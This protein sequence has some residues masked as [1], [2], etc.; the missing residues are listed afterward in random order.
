LSATIAASG[1]D[2]SY[3]FAANTLTAVEKTL[4]LKKKQTLP[5]VPG[6][7]SPLFI[8]L[9]SNTW[10]GPVTDVTFTPVSV[11]TSTMVVIV[12]RGS[13]N[14]QLLTSHAPA[15]GYD[16]SLLNV[17]ANQLT[18]VV[19]SVATPLTFTSSTG[20]GSST[21][22]AHTET[23]THT[24]SGETLASVLELRMRVA[25][26]VKYTSKVG[27]GSTSPVSISVSVVLPLGPPTPYRVAGAPSVA[28]SNSIYM[29]NNGN[30]EV[31]VS[32]NA[33]GLAVEG[34]STVVAFISQNSNY[35]DSADPQSGDAPMVLAVFGPGSDRT[36]TVGSNAS[37]IST[38]D[39]LAPG[40]VATTTSENL[41]DNIDDGAAPLPLTLA[42]GTLAAG[43]ATVLSF[44]ATGF[45]PTA[46]IQIILIVTTRLG[47]RVL[48]PTTLNYQAPP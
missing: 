9:A 12:K 47:H 17:T 30:I 16:S 35:S 38:T 37:A 8:T 1:S 18:K 46:P 29:V 26:G 3:V 34:L 43:D 5:A 23:N 44:S 4:A 45:N 27:A 20:A 36:Y 24:L 40:E 14:T 39:N 28:S 33:N 21:V 2:F 22:Q 41:S 25:A 42:L 10:Y 11:D 31:P 19:G 15:T 6:T 7:S 13:N 48:P 32:I